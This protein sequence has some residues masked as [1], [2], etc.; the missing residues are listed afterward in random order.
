ME[1]IMLF[2]LKKE[3]IDEQKDIL[4]NT[5]MLTGTFLNL[6]IYIPQS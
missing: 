5:M 4:K 3:P 6:H 1:I 2:G